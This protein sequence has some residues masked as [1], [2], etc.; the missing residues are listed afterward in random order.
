MPIYQCTG[1]NNNGK[2][3]KNKIT[4]EF[5]LDYNE[6]K[7]YHHYNSF[8]FDIGICYE[9]KEECNPCSQLC[10]RCARQLTMSALGWY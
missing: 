8:N 4:S 2:R 5:K 1:K 10:G 9:C 3:C 6:R 7:C